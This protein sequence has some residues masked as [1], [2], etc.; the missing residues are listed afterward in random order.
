MPK[1]PENRQAL[2][3][4]SRAYSRVEQAIRFVQ[5]HQRRQPGLEEIAASVHLTPYHFQRLF[6]RWAGLTPKRFLQ[7]LTKED[8]KRRLRASASVLETA[9]AAGLSGP[10]RLHELL[11][12]CEA[13]TPGEVRRG[14]A[15]VEIRFGFHPSLFGECL[16][17]TTP[18]GICALRFVGSDG[19][20]AALDGVR[21]E[22]PQARWTRDQRAT[23]APA[24]A[25]GASGTPAHGLRL[26]L[27]GTNF[28]LK[29]WEALLALPPGAVTTY[30][31]IA[32]ALGKPGAS[33][34]VGGAVAENPIALLIPCHRVLRNSGAP[35][36]YRWG[37]ARKQAILALES[38]PRAALPAVAA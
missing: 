38:A 36:G 9:L 5:A 4:Q 20:L 24:A 29:V 31:E 1:Q 11:V 26:H 33:R 28:Q 17:A 7:F 10:G 6:Q 19:R 30:G 32:R 22:W 8:A 18:R 37:S 21:Q 15:G 12:D 2:T 16:L 3:R 23:A 25:L 14:G 13:V 34:A 35:G 27:R